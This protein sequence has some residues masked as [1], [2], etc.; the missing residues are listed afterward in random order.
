MTEKEYESFIYEKCFFFQKHL[1][2]EEY[3]RKN[4]LLKEKTEDILKKC[5]TTKFNEEYTYIV[6]NDSTILIFFPFD[7]ASHLYGVNA[8]YTD[9]KSRNQGSARRLLKSLDFFGS[10][11]FPTYTPELIGLLRSLGAK[12]ENIIENKPESQFILDINKKPSS[13]LIE[14]V[15]R[16]LNEDEC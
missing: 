3:V 15:M 8:I 7:Y 2:Y 1:T 5:G 13:K 14:E 6:E 16:K 12:E 11:Y 10:L 9:E 4:N